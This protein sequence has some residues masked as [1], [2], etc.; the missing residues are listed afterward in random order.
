MKKMLL[1][2]PATWPRVWNPEARAA[3]A[4]L[5]ERGRYRGGEPKLLHKV[6]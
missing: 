2:K 6:S 1:R 3:V 4:A 5:G